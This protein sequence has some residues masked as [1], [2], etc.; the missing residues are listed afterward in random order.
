MIAII[1]YNLSNLNCVLS[2]INFCGYNAKITNDLK[3]IE[4]ANKIILPGVGAFPDAMLNLKKLNLI[5]ILNEKVLNLKTPVLGICLGAQLI[6]N[7]SNEFGLNKG[8]GWIDF[9]VLKLSPKKRIFRVPH[10]GWNEIRIHNKK[11]VLLNQIDEKDNLFYFN[12]S[13]FIQNKNDNGVTA[14]SSHGKEF[15]AII[16][17]NNIFATQFHPEKSQKSGLKV[18]ENFLGI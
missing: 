15:V 3:E 7:M 11:S 9:D 10:T 13:Y 2:A 5:N 12:H 18:I 4:N 14:T 16:E 1:N 8:L 17:K 6:C